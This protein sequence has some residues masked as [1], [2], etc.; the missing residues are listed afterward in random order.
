[1][2]SCFTIELPNVE[3]GSHI[4]PETEKKYLTPEKID[5]QP[6]TILVVDDIQSNRHLINAFLQ[7]YT[8][9]TLIEADTGEKALELVSAYQFDLILM[10]KILPDL[11][12]ETVCEKIRTMP[13]CK[14]IPIIM[15][16][17]SAL[18]STNEQHA[19]F[20][21][22][23]INKPVSKNEL[24]SAMQLFLPIVKIPDTLIEITTENSIEDVMKPEKRQELVEL[25][26]ERYLDTIKQLSISGVFK[27][28]VFIEL[29]EQLLTLAEQ[30]H[31]SPLANWA[32]S[33]KSQ[34]ELFDITKL[35]RTLSGFEKLLKELMLRTPE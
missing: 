16:T 19:V 18:S 1:V 26:T 12:G 4:K 28:A 27:I 2:G 9:L 33:L 25:L 32:N 30:T 29:A 20:Y 10:D 34:A 31:C 22:T 5:F 7:N 17:A 11:D 3:I 14:D 13:D 6:A 35:A 24:L 23:R 8:E 21:N 15:L